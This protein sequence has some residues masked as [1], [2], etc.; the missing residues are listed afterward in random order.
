MIVVTVMATALER[1]RCKFVFVSEREKKCENKKRNQKRLICP[2]QSFTIGKLSLYAVICVAPH[3]PTPH[4]IPRP[5]PRTIRHILALLA[6]EN[7]GK[8]NLR[9]TNIIIRGI[10]CA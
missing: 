4:N 5:H 3:E 1:S 9:T 7:S 6:A 2:D 8:T 10:R